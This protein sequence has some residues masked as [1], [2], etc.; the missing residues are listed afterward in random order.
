MI[1]SALTWLIT[2]SWQAVALTAISTVVLGLAP[3]TN[4]STRYLAWWLT[5]VGVLALI[6]IPWNWP[7][8]T[9]QASAGVGGS[10]PLPFSSSGGNQFTVVEIP[11]VP[12]WVLSVVAA[13][14]LAY[15][16]R[17]LII[18]LRS[19]VRL[20][21][22]KRR[23]TPLPA[24]LERRLSHWS[25]VRGMGRQARLCFSEDV[26]TGCM[27]GLGSPVI[28]LPRDLV[29]ALSHSDLDRVVIHEYGHVQRRDDW[30]TAAQASIEALLGWHPAV[31]WI[32]R[33]LR[34]E[35]E[36]AC[37]DWVLLRT[38]SPRDYA[39]S[40]TR[41]AALALK[42]A[43]LPFASR[44]L[45]SRGELVGRVE[46]LLDP[47]RNAAIQPIRSILATGTLALGTVVVLLGHT[48]PVVTVGGSGT[49]TGTLSTVSAFS[50]DAPLMM[51]RVAASRVRLGAGD[52][53][54]AGARMAT[55]QPEELSSPRIVNQATL[56]P[57]VEVR[58]VSGLRPSDRLRS[59][60]LRPRAKPVLRSSELSID[61]EFAIPRDVP[62]ASSA[63]LRSD[64]MTMTRNTNPS[65]WKQ[66]A[67]AGKAVGIGA[68]DAGV[69]TASAFQ[70]VGSSIARVFAGS[71]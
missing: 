38:V 16:G 25:S 69:A 54:A 14:W 66:I 68:S 32:G 57:S 9:G 20:R 67:S 48:P 13:L 63:K 60:L 51:P 41:L 46:R 17:R 4:A 61:A 62:I 6:V 40:L 2:W 58:A 10:L 5:L 18:L 45:R 11:A 49:R 50:F 28:A 71:R 64:Q 39:S 43:T 31:W 12:F 26:A 56:F 21:I 27:L 19:I 65:P 8:G 3:R 29:A 42:Q 35:R 59:A 1:N 24:R 22:V 36:V 70:T 53:L 30:A 34:L 33:N 55:N 47:M 23:C 15:S 44:A 37:D 7:L 52:M